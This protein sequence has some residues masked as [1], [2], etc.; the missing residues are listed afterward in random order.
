MNC[1]FCQ[2]PNLRVLISYEHYPIFIG[3][4]DRPRAEDELYDFALFL[5]RDCG[6]IQQLA[7]PP[8][9]I[10]YREPRFFGRGRTWNNHYD[11][12]HA[13]I[14]AE[15]KDAASVLEIGGGP[16][17]MLRRF[18]DSGRCLRLFDVEPHPIYDIPEVTTFRCY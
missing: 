14:A 5:C 3:C 9:D 4:S 6:V 7:L 1:R 8:L 17:L 2:S 13:F 16:G 18:R 11:A 15:L 10:L 12:Y